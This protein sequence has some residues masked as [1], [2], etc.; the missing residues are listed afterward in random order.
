LKK[1]INNVYEIT[2]LLKA[3]E[4]AKTVMKRRNKELLDEEIEL[5]KDEYRLATIKEI[6]I[7]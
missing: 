3:M 7:L 1:M 5:I 6:K 2:P 4:V